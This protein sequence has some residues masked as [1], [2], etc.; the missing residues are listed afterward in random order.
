MPLGLKFLPLASIFHGHVKAEIL[1]ELNYSY[2]GGI[3]LFD[4]CVLLPVI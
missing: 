4:S 1:I 3:T 2:L